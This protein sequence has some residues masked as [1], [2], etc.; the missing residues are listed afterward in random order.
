MF[1][2]KSRYRID[3][4]AFSTMMKLLSSGFPQSELPKSY[5]EAKKYL[6]EL[7]LALKTSMCARIIVYC[8]ERDMKKLICVQYARRLDG[9]MKQ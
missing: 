6:G 3:N 8:F 9:K 2:I 4:T 1:Y 5:D 7:G